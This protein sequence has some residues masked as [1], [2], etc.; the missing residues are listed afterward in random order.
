MLREDHARVLA[1]L[2]RV[3]ALM[4]GRAAAEA[5]GPEAAAGAHAAALAAVRALAARLEVQFATH[6]AAEDGV[7][8][9][10]IAR[11]LDQGARLVAPLHVEHDDLRTMLAALAAR[12]A[13]APDPD[14]D[15]QVFVQARDLVDLLRIHIRKEEA[16]VFSVAE[17]VLG[18]DD[19]AALEARRMPIPGSTPGDAP[20]TPKG[21]S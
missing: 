16:L 13:C 20:T 9:P 8:Y 7:L 14:R 6:L 5:V 1:D 10:A 12:L 11:A 18:P 15:E 21:T 17:R 19:L 4:S 2:E 3:D